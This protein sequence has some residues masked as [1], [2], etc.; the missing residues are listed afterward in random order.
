MKRF[1]VLE[2]V[3]YKRKKTFK[4]YILHIWVWGLG[5]YEIFLADTVS[6]VNQGI[7]IIRFGKKQL[8]LKR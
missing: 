1:P 3:F 6:K 2:F 5:P 4:K 8:T 7:G